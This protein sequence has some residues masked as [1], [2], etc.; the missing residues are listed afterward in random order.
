VKR[1][2]ATHQFVDFMPDELKEGVIYVSIEFATASHLCMCGCG[3]TVVTPIT[4]RDW[5]LTF[6]GE[7]VS[8]Q[9]SVGSWSL[10]CESHYFIRR[11]RVVWSSKLS[12][13]QIAHIRAAD[14][15]AKNAFFN[16]SSAEPIVVPL[17]STPTVSKRGL[18]QRLFGK[19]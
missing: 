13:D 1:R 9:P 16:P 19:R 2:S 8:L 10:P 18:W 11:D 4:P 12:S 15:T 5:Q 3:A 6:D 14:L 17:G 7:T